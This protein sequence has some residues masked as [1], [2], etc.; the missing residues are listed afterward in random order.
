[1]K[2][3]V[4]HTESGKEDKIVCQCKK[5]II[6]PGEDVFTP[7][8][9]RVK[10]IHGQD[11]TIWS[12]M[13]EGYVFAETDDPQ[14]MYLRVRAGLGNCIFGYLHVLR[15]D[16]YILPLEPEEE[17]M[18]RGLMDDEHRVRMSYGYKT[19]D[20]AVITEGPLKNFRGRIVGFNQ[21]RKMAIIETRIL[22]DR[23]QI[24]VG[25]D[26]MRKEE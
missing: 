17:E 24:A 9:E 4:M 5:N 15:N 12:N 7:V 10:R 2:L 8:V 16:E 21:H 3:Y 19:G 1:M 26:M 13:Y 6:E 18:L 23:R 11:L 25:A 20:E 22:G 14:D